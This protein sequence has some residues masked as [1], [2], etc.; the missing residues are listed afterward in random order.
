MSHPLLQNGSR[1]HL[2]FVHKTET[3]TR[4]MLK[5]WVPHLPGHVSG[6]VAVR[7]KLQVAAVSSS[8]IHHVYLPRLMRDNKKERD[9]KTCGRRLSWSLQRVSLTWSIHNFPTMM[10][11][12]VV[13]T[14]FHV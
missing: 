2:R 4:E 6:E 8:V 12:T 5:R 11:C 3:I 9:V 1:A 13:V 14:F 10:L 7:C